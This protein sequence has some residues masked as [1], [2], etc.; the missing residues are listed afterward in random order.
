MWAFHHVPVILA[1]VYGVW[2]L[3]IYKTL[4]LAGGLITFIAGTIILTAGMATFGSYDRSA[5]KDI[6]KLIT[7]GIYR[8]SRNPQFIG[9][10]LMLLGISFMG[11]SG[12]ALALTVL[13]IIVL[14]WYTVRLAEPYL[15]HLHGEEYLMYKSK[16]ARWIGRPK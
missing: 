16:A 10:A 13:F 2:P 8:W 6:S 5:G 9:W 14:Y 4:A 3:L 12:F 15:E 1:S 11:R 7:T